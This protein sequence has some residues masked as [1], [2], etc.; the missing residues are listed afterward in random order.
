MRKLKEMC[1]YSGGH[2]ILGTLANALTF[3]TVDSWIK[4]F[5][6]CNNSYLENGFVN[7]VHP[8]TEKCEGPYGFKWN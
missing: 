1:R 5:S 3:L 2:T 8:L 7:S 6:T 4:L